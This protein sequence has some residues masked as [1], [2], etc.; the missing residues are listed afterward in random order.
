MGGIDSRYNTT[1]Q[2]V[3]IYGRRFILTPICRRRRRRLV[4]TTKVFSVIKSLV[5]HVTH[6]TC[7]SLHLHRCM[8]PF[9]SCSTR[10]RS[11][12]EG[13]GHFISGAVNNAF[14][15]LTKSINQTDR[16]GGHVESYW[17][18]GKNRE[19]FVETYSL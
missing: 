17:V 9:C 11:H 2:Q 12:D 3:K 13:G 4:R 10:L 16:N 15:S 19:M 6:V 8:H 7:G 14:C 5:R 18:P 1:L